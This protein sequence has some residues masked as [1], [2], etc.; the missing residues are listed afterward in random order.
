MVAGIGGGYI[1]LLSVLISGPMLLRAWLL[2]CRC[3][4][5]EA[6]GRLARSMKECGQKWT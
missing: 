6:E 2:S 1:A 3:K 4:K 5:C